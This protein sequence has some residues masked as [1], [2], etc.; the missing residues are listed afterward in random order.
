MLKVNKYDAN[1]YYSWTE[2]LTSVDR[3]ILIVLYRTIYN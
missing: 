2:L 3:L 1:N